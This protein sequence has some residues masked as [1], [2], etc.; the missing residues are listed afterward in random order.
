MT[1]GHCGQVAPVRPQEPYRTQD[2][3]FYGF[4][5]TCRRIMTL[6]RN[7]R[8]AEASILFRRAESLRDQWRAIVRADSDS[9]DFVVEESCVATTV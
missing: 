7:D 9:T 2:R 5:R 3:L 6:S 8:H 1:R 4:A